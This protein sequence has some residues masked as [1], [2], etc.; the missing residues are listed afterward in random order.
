MSFVTKTDYKKFVRTN[1]LD[2]ILE[3]DDSIL[4]D[5]ESTAIA[6]IQDALYSRFDIDTIFNATGDDRAAQVVRWVCVLVLYFV[7]ERIP[8]ALVPERV[9]KN[10]NDVMNLLHDVADGKKSLNLP[11]LVDSEGEIKSKF[12]WG[13]E[14]RRTHT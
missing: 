2:M 13:S 3:Q 12:R 9:V 11:R 6:M 7:Y 1:Q 14:T 10:Y 5:A 4:D 8:D